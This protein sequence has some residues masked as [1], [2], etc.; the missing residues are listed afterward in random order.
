MRFVE[1]LQQRF[2]TVLHGPLQLLVCNG[3]RYQYVHFSTWQL[4]A[5]RP[6]GSRLCDQEIE[7]LIDTDGKFPHRKPIK[8]FHAREQARTLEDLGADR[9]LEK[10]QRPLL[11]RLRDDAY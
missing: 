7:R 11:I 1:F 10:I 6:W 2:A 3:R 9:P 5:D 4:G 8:L